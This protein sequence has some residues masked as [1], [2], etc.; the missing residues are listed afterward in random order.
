MMQ[1]RVASRGLTGPRLSTATRSASVSVS[2][3][4]PRSFTSLTRELTMP[5]AEATASVLSASGHDLQPLTVEQKAKVEKYLNKR[6]QSVLLQKQAEPAHNGTTANG[7]KYNSTLCGT[8]ACVMGGL[9]VFHSCAKVDRGFGYPT[10]TACIDEAHISE[11]LVMLGMP[12]SDPGAGAA[13]TNQVLLP[14]LRRPGAVW[15]EVQDVR[16]KAH[17]GYMVSDTDGTMYY[18]INATALHFIPQGMEI[19]TKA[20]RFR[21]DALGTMGGDLD[22]GEDSEEG[23]D[24]CAEKKVWAMKYQGSTKQESRIEFL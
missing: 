18:C 19:P 8:Y 7:F 20:W 1:C 21:S 3:T 24:L 4:T 22:D 17:L 15:I 6:Q 2:M 23:F 10:F 14:A 5:E 13:V 12:H 16:A 9:P 11:E